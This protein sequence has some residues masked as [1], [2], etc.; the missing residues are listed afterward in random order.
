VTFLDPI[1]QEALEEH[2]WNARKYKKKSLR[3]LRRLL[4]GENFDIALL[5]V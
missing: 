5:H 2:G 4:G 1:Q 3:F